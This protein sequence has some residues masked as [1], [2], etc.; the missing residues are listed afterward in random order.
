MV[1][2]PHKGA[3]TGDKITEGKNKQHL[4]VDKY[5]SVR[6]ELTKGLEQKHFISE[7]N[8]VLANEGKCWSEF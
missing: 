1:M 4:S 6:Q 3:D 5:I 2:H 8:N 7:Q